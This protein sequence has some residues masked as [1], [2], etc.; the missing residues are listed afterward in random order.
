MTPKNQMHPRNT[1]LYPLQSSPNFLS[2]ATATL[3]PI[4]RTYTPNRIF[5]PPQNLHS[6]DAFSFRV[7]R[8][9]LCS[10]I[11]LLSISVVIPSQ[12]RGNVSLLGNF[13]SSFHPA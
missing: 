10:S 7:G 13:S 9:N 1:I 12:L 2:T 4:H 5:P 6:I 8:L 11:H 3:H